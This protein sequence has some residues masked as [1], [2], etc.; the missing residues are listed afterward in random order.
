M[1]NKQIATDLKCMP[2]NKV[3][4]MTLEEAYTLIMND[5]KDIYQTRD[6]I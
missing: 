5:I 2:S 6:A 1:Y 4:N 3:G